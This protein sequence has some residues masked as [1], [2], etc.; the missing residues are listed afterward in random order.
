MKKKSMSFHI[1]AVCQRVVEP[2]AKS[3]GMNLIVQIV[4]DLGA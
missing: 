1:Q 2:N 3:E 4:A